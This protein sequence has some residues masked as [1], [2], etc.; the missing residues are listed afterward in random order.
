MFD[1]YFNPPLSVIYL[2]QVAD[3][4]RA[5]DIADSPVSTLIVQDA[6]STSIPS[7]KEQEQEQSLTISQGV[8]E[9]PKTPHF[10]DDPLHETLHEDSTS[11]GSSSNV[12]PSHTPFELLSKWTKNHPIENMIGDPSRSVSTR[13]QIQ[14]DAMWCYF[15]AFLTLV[16]P[17]TYKEA[18][19]EPSELM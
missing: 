2:V 1:E 14:T 12:R 15:D 9:S 4:S 13:N 7:T 18:M 8:E 6:P 11:Q 10:H 19:I 3:T 17:K 16:E 5:V